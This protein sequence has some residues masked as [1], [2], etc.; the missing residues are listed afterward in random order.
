MDVFFK[1]ICIVIIIIILKSFI[2][3]FEK[4]Q[5]KSPYQLLTSGKSF[6]TTACADTFFDRKTEAH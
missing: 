6:D 4:K 5:V 1:S 3:F 2:Q